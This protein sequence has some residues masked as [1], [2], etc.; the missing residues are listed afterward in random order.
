MTGAHEHRNDWPKSSK[1][2]LQGSLPFLRRIHSAWLIVVQL[3][4]GDLFCR[5]AASRLVP[6]DFGTSS[7]HQYRATGAKSGCNLPKV[8]LQGVASKALSTT[9]QVTGRAP[10]DIYRKASAARSFLKS[11][12]AMAQA[13][14]AHTSRRVFR[15]PFAFGANCPML[16]NATC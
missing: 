16:E 12:W 3:G 15:N 2:P 10:L 9:N 6:E 5:P 4:S 8:T 7:R 11:L 13:A 1:V 14:I